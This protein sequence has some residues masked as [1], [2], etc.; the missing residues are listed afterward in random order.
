M[1]DGAWITVASSII[2][3]SGVI[4]T[5]IIKAPFRRNGNGIVDSNKCPAHSGLVAKIESLEEGQ[6]RIEN[7]QIGTR[8][9]ID[10]MSRD[11]RIFIEKHGMASDG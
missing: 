6:G 10:V 3:G 11:L 5:A 8:K 7:G 2:G 1:T 4:I 9:V